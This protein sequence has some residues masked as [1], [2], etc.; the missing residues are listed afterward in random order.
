MPSRRECDLFEFGPRNVVSSQVLEVFLIP[1]EAQLRRHLL[2]E[3]MVHTLYVPCRSMA[4]IA[5]APCAPLRKPLYRI[6]DFPYRDL[7]SAG[8]RRLGA[9]YGPHGSTGSIL[10]GEPAVHGVGAGRARQRGALQQGL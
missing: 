2:L 8:H 1:I 5:T 7:P 10:R 3:S 9:G 6:H 4:I